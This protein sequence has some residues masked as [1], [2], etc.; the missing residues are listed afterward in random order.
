MEPELMLCAGCVPAAPFVE[1]TAAASGAGFEAISIWPLMYRRAT[2]REGLDPVTMRRIVEDHGIRISD[3]DACGAWLPEPS[4]APEV[5]NMFRS[6]WQREEFFDVAGALAIE[7]LTAAHLTGGDVDRD[8]A[9]EGFAALCD[10]AAA[11]G[12]TVA[13]EFMPFSGIPDLASAEAIVA[14]AGRSNGGLVL[15]LCHLVRSGGGIE[16]VAGLAPG[17]IFSIQLGDGRRVAP[18]DLREEAMFHRDLPGAGEF[19]LAELVAAALARST[20]SVR[21]RI[22]PEVYQRG[23]SERDPRVV[24]ADLME[25]TRQVL[26]GPQGDLTWT[27][28]PR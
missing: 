6:L 28:P 5:P 26:G 9:I 21:V 3:L 4:D 8:I 25:A 2:T 1:L 12:M 14:G 19:G 27:R 23:F 10:D 20:D 22:G 7:S 16:D 15:D 24:S 18:A 11:H 17:R 13:L